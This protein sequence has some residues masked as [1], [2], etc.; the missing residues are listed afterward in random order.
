M[1]DHLVRY[2]KESKIELKKVTWPSRE[3]TIR[4]TA[5]VIAVSAAVAI[6]LGGVDYVL[7]LGL[8]SFVL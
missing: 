3:E 1:F 2:L 6:F 4:Y 7:Q 5:M 8:N